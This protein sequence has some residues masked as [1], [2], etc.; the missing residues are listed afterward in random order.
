MQASAHLRGWGVTISQE[1]R[2]RPVPEKGR[3]SKARIKKSEL[4]N[5]LQLIERKT[6][7]E[8]ESCAKDQGKGGKQK[9]D[10]RGKRLWEVRAASRLCHGGVRK[11]GGEVSEDRTGSGAASLSPSRTRSGWAEPRAAEAPCI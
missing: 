10:F 5:E 11:P 6:G 1:S 9:G 3:Q 2:N 8:Q 4:R 7:K